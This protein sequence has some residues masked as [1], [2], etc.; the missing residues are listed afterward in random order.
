VKSEDRTRPDFIGLRGANTQSQC[1]AGDTLKSFKGSTTVG[2]FLVPRT[3]LNCS[4][5]WRNTAKMSLI[6]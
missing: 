6:L 2:H 4:A 1:T 5:W 3:P